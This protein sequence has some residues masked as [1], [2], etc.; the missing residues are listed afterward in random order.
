M[1]YMTCNQKLISGSTAN[2]LHSNHHEL[3]QSNKV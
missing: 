3:H 1:V 2:C